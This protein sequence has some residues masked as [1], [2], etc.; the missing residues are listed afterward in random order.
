LLSRE[1]SFL[2]NNLLLVGIAFATLWGTIFPVIS[3]AVRGVKITVGPPFFN[4]VNT[5]IGLALLGLTGLCPL[6]AWRK[7]SAENLS[8]NFFLPF[9]VAI[10]GAVV[11]YLWGI[12]QLYPFLSFTISLF[13]VATIFLDFYR[14]G[15]ARREM[16]GGSF[17]GGL[18][19][20]LIRNKRRYGG[21]I[22][23]LGIVLVFIGITG[24]AF[25]MDKQIT[26]N[27]G[28]SFTI[29]HYTIRY[30]S[31]SRYPTENKEVVAATLSVFNADKRVAVLAPEKNLH[32]GHDQPTTEVAIHSTLMKDLYVILAGY[33]GEMATFKV[34]VNPLVVWLWIGGGVMALGTI[35]ALFPDRRRVKDIPQQKGDGK[36]KR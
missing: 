22:V 12:R 23:H 7:A 14:G 20:L 15:R 5:P 31:L 17:P 11:L 26:A 30:D 34:L 21:Y 2:Y 32:R 6:I 36:E 28:D 18:W 19:S 13:V 10:A 35:L 1:S 3:E 24:N 8:R 25:K 29:K 27:K 16:T 33:E 9:T 4:K